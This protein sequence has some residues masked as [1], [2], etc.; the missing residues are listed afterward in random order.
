MASNADIRVT[1]TGV[2]APYAADYQY[3]FNSSWPSLPIAF[4][5]TIDVPYLSSVPIPH[6]LKIYPLTMGWV[7]LNNV[8]LGRIFAPS[9][10]FGGKQADVSLTFDNKNVYLSNFGSNPVTYTVS[11]KC[12]NIDIS[13]AVD[14][15]L[16]RQPTVRTAYDPT[17]GIK[18]VKHS[19]SIGSKD[20]R[21]FI[22]HSRAQSP[23]V[24]S[25]VT[26]PD[27]D[28]R[29]AYNN[30]A[31]Y[32]PWTLAF[33]G[34]PGQNTTYSPLAPGAQQ[35]G[36]RFT[37][38]SDVQAKNSNTP[39]SYIDSSGI[40]IPNASFGSLVVLRDPLVVPNV[41]TVTYNG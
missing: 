19:K 41:R 40:V 35:A 21:D 8:N 38:L 28:K 3:V 5:E 24:L 23:A 31:N 18:V 1:Q 33:V 6:G 11:I 32:T 30:P 29:I 15:T 16:P 14:Y 2:S 22:L 12:Y 13:K 34:G 17:T 26:K 39:Q 36:Y 27:K 7:L 9:G 20:L 10:N 37:L 4:E 25:I